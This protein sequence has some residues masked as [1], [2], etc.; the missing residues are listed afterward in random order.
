MRDYPGSTDSVEALRALKRRIYFWAVT[1]GLL[2]ILA[3]WIPA[4]FAGTITSFER[5]IFPA[6]TAL[7]LGL[8]IVLWRTPVALVWVE[9]SLFAGTALTL[10][11]RLVEILFTPEPPSTPTIWR[12]SPICSTGSR[13]SMCWR[14]SYLK[15][16]AGCWSVRCCSSPPPWLWG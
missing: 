1:A 11:A 6:T 9:L 5:I 3:A 7:C 10:L 12:R 16:A 4:A 14:F 8:L 13:W 2:T 15:A